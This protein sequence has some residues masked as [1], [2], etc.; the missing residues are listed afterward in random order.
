MKRLITILLLLSIT[1]IVGCA[2]CSNGWKHLQSTV[3]GLKRKI[4]LYNA[5]GETIRVWETKAKVEDQ[6]GTCYFLDDDG[7]SMIISGTFIIEEL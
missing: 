5:N 3:T 1:Q 4:S 2:G 6:G 7:K